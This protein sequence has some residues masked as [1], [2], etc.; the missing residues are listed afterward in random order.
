LSAA[1]AGP[2]ATAATCEIVL[3]DAVLA[4]HPG[5]RLAL[6]AV[7]AGRYSDPSETARAEQQVLAELLAAFA[8]ED[9][10][11]AG[12]ADELYRSFYRSMGLKAAQVST[13]VKQALRVLRNCEYRARGPVVDTAMAIEYSTLVSFQVYSAAR[14]GGRLAFR[15]AGGEEPITT[16]RGEAKTCKP[17][18]LLLL[19]GAGGEVAHSC[20]YGNDPAFLLTEQDELAIVRVMGVPGL[21]DDVLA[22]AVEEAERRMSPVDAITLDAATT[23]GR[24]S[25]TSKQEG[26]PT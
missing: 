9:E 6:L 12:P 23:R 26:G 24:L 22:R 11:R 16:M 1:Q 25:L 4:Q 2:G 5:L 10:L 20:Y 13:P 8:D 3:D 18:E 21:E 15:L 19:G 17:G 7:P 14:L